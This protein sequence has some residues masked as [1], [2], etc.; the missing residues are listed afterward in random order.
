V[1][2]NLLIGVPGKIQLTWGDSAS[3][4]GEKGVSTTWGVQW[5]TKSQHLKNAFGLRS[6][7]QVYLRDVLEEKKA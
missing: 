7:G 1:A 6:V 4:M 3:S 2:K 5:C